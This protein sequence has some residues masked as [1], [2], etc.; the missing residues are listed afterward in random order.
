MT[1][2]RFTLIELLVVIAIIAILASLLMPALGRSR[3]Q[4]QTA[5]CKN[6]LKQISIALHVYV[7]ERGTFPDAY[8]GGGSNYIGLYTHYI[9]KN[10]NGSN[11]WGPYLGITQ[12]SVGALDYASAKGLF[13]DPVTG[14][15][16]AD[17]DLG[18]FTIPY[19]YNTSGGYTAVNPGR[20][21]NPSQA[22][23]LADAGS[24][25]STDILDVGQPWLFPG[26]VSRR[27]VQWRHVDAK[28]N[29][30]LADGHAETGSASTVTTAVYWS[31]LFN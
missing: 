9:V 28:A 19:G 25:S 12:M 20:I 4:A 31:N 1:R 13:N 22:Y 14:R 3:G 23:Q 16:W 21:T 15:P 7:A 18:F 10:T 6:N 17:T 24:S 26:F 30:L 11:Q 5:T 2:R 8:I 29:V 27:N